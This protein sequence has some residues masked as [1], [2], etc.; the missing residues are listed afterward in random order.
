MR[1]HPPVGFDPE[2]EKYIREE[3]KFNII[4]TVISIVVL[5]F[6]IFAFCYAN[7]F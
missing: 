6:V 3:K 1:Y 4:I 5:A 2:E 7:F